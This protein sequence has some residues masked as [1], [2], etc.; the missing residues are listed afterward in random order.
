MREPWGRK[1]LGVRWA[2]TCVG[3]AIVLALSGC[4]V[5]KVRGAIVVRTLSRDS[6]TSILGRE[7]PRMNAAGSPLDADH[8]VKSCPRRSVVAG[9]TTKRR[10]SACLSRHASAS[11]Q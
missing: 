10:E 11:D 1:A 3:T 9:R 5:T 4:T 8:L 6:C 7:E 2:A